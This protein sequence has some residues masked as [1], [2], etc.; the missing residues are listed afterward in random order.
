MAAPPQKPTLGKDTLK[1][2]VV[3]EVEKPNDVFDTYG[4]FI[5]D[6]I[7]TDENG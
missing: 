6:I 1:C 7:V 4:R 3:T 5:G 2:R